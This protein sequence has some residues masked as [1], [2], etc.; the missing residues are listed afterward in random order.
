[1]AGQF[2]EIWKH[3]QEEVQRSRQE[4]ELKRRGSMAKLMKSGW[5]I[6]LFVLALVIGACS[7]KETV[8]PVQ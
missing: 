5:L 3:L 8:K 2:V 7:P 1:M 6:P 4:D